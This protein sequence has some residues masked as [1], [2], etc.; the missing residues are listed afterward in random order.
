M[1]VPTYQPGTILVEAGAILPG[2]VSLQPGGLSQIWRSVAN[3]DKVALAAEL[4]QAG[5][6]FFYMAGVVQKHAFG[7]DEET[8]MRAAVGRV[9]KEVEA[10]QC[11]CLEL[12]SFVTKSFLGVPYVSVTAHARHIQDGCQFRGHVEEAR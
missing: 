1:S 3:L 7:F 4:A 9:I 6:T 10:Q 12:T 2:S 11:N 8:R 5:W